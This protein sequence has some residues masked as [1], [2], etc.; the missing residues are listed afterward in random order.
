KRARG[1][2]QYRGQSERCSDRVYGA[3][4]RDA[5]YGEHA[6][7]PALREAASD[8][9]QSVLARREVQEESAENEQREILSAEHELHYSRSSIAQSVTVLSKSRG[10]VVRYPR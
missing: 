4:G 7:A 3:P 8:D 10:L 6:R 2:S 5:T 9:V 1:G